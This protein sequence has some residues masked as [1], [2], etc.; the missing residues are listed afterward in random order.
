MERL[1]SILLSL[2][3]LVPRPGNS[4]RQRR[5]SDLP[6]T[7]IESYRQ[8]YPRYTALLTANDSFFVFR[9]FSRARARLLLLKQDRISVLD[10]ELDRIDLEEQCPLFL[11]KSRLDA[12]ADRAA[13]LAQLDA[14]LA[15]YDSLAERS[16]KIMSLS[17]AP[18]RDVL[19]LKN[20]V[21]GTGSLDC[22]ETAY[23]GHSG[24]LASLVLPGDSAT[25][26]LGSWIEDGLIRSSK[27]FRQSP[28]LDISSDPNVYIYSGTLIKRLTK[29]VLLLI[30]V[31]LLLAPVIVCN[32][33]V[34]TLARLII[35]VF[36]SAVFLSV[37]DLLMRVRPFE[38]ILAGATYV[39]VLTVF[40]SRTADGSS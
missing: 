31:V 17:R 28:G 4:D 11:G 36:F 20:W 24:D 35:I 34:S 14:S 23:L 5:G 22:D 21:N 10:K 29:V 26:Q 8:G 39:T 37:V 15:D 25:T 38:L 1:R 18:A 2:G 13:V 12:N 9:K 30:I 16:H 40:V 19:N 7:Q 27:S 3:R 32:S 6:I 33:I